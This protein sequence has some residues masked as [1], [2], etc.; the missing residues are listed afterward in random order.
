M[1]ISTSYLGYCL[2]MLT[3]SK[4]EK[5]DSAWVR[6]FALNF[7]RRISK[8]AELRGKFEN[9]P[10]KYVLAR[11]RGFLWPSNMWVLIVFP[12]LWLPKPI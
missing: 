10:Q 3:L 1:T 2:E 11:A 5:F 8:N 12:G 4:V 6:R 9:D 7:E